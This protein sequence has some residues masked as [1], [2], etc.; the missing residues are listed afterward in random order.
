ML[1]HVT[2]PCLSLYDYVEFIQFSLNYCEGLC[3]VVSLQEGLLV[4]VVENNRSE[5]L[6]LQKGIQH[7][8]PT[9]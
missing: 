8:M 7:G 2:E 3:I 5:V 4:Q 9:Q 1:Y 6:H